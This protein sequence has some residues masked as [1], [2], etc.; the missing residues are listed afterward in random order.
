MQERD[1]TVDF[2]T[3]LL[4]WLSR[5][6]GQWF[7]MDSNLTLSPEDPSLAFIQEAASRVNSSSPDYVVLFEAEQDLI[8]EAYLQKHDFFQ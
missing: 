5:A 7:L 8:L 2:T 4:P 3:A 6:I 1:L